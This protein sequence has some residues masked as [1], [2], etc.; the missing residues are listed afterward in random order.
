MV[1]VEGKVT[2]PAPAVAVE[3]EPPEPEV[4]PDEADAEPPAPAP[5]APDAEAAAEA[6]AVDVPMLPEVAVFDLPEDPDEIAITSAMTTTTP[7]PAPISS[8]ALG[9]FGA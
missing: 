8:A 2:V 1:S 3:V 9:F 5:D 4:A 6:D 7:I